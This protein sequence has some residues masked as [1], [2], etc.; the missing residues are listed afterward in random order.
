[1]EVFSWGTR[2]KEQGRGPPGPPKREGQNPIIHLPGPAPCVEELYSDTGHSI[3]IQ[4]VG[5]FARSLLWSSMSPP[6]FRRQ[7]GGEPAGALG[8]VDLSLVPWKMGPRPSATNP[9]PLAT[10]HTLKLKGPGP[11]TSST[12]P[13]NKDP[14]W[15]EQQFGMPCSLA[16]CC[17]MPSFSS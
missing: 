12:L 11:G 17:T 1:M 9:M 2:P 7:L 13:A 5:W 8:C 10:P 3:D 4:W 14:P 16:R 6:L 15:A